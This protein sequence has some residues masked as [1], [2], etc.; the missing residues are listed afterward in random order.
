MP[1][2]TITSTGLPMTAAGSPTIIATD[3][4]GN[5]LTITI[6]VTEAAPAD[7]DNPTVTVKTGANIPTVDGVAL[8]DTTGKDGSDSSKAFE[9]I[10]TEGKAAS[11]T[12][13]NIKSFFTLN[14]ATPPA[15]GLAF[16]GTIPSL[17]AAGATATDFTLT[18]TDAASTPNVAT[19]HFKVSVAEVPTKANLDSK[20]QALGAFATAPTSVATLQAE[21]RKITGI[22]GINKLRVIAD[23]QASAPGLTAGDRYSI[24][25]DGKYFTLTLNDDAANAST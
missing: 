3:A 23:V 13:E 16:A 17:P 1:G 15:N 2:L 21:L 9:F 14:D 18:V 8:G 22:A 5:S 24:M 11:F 25:I 10:V 4:A 7:S 20:I 12:L 6:A 19:I